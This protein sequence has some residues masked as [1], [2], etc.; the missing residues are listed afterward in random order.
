MR[1]SEQIISEQNALNPIIPTP[2]MREIGQENL[3]KIVYQKQLSKAK[4]VI[5]KAI[6]LAPKYGCTKQDLFN[7]N[8]I[9]KLIEKYP[10]LTTLK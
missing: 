7:M 1:L 4:K 3:E 10:E 8:C 5:N 9:V 6:N 2:E